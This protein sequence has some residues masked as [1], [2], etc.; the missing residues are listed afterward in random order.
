MHGRHRT[1]LQFSWFGWHIST[2]ER[3]LTHPWGTSQ[4]GRA[5][6]FQAPRHVLRMPQ[7]S[8]KAIIKSGRWCFN[9]EGETCG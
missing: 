9:S 5:I 2:S 7:A 4:L 3:G 1:L 6:P 8:L